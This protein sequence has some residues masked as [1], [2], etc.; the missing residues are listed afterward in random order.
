M[1]NCHKEPKFTIKV[2]EVPPAEPKFTIKVSEV[3]PAEVWTYTIWINIKFYFTRRVPV[4]KTFKY[5]IDDSFGNEFKHWWYKN[6]NFDNRHM[7]YF[8]VTIT[9][10]NENKSFVT[11]EGYDQLKGKLMEGHRIYNKQIKPFLDK[12]YSTTIHD[13]PKYQ[14]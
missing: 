13:P 9:D 11:H 5:E 1:G 4:T 14:E 2:S 10:N 6:S 7:M 3:P 8:S 12:N